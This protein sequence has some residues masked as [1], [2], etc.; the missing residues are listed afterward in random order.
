MQSRIFGEK[1]A[2]S[3][4][5]LDYAPGHIGLP[6]TINFKK[7][8][9]DKKI[10][11]GEILKKQ[12]YTFYFNPETNDRIESHMK[13][14]GKS[15]RSDFVEEAVNFYCGALD[16]NTHRSFLGDEVIKTMQAIV[17]DLEGR[18][19]SHFRSQDISLSML[20]VLFAANLT[21][22]TSDEIAEQRKLAVQ[23]VNENR[24]AKSFVTA[25]RDEQ[26]DE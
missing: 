14:L 19:F 21:G 5:F 17:R 9:T 22:M 15:S 1:W 11:G 20:A 18:I 16:A 23:Y 8:Y 6:I 24:S 4:H 26:G 13:E 3:A 10:Q 12:H 7:L 25:L 2:I